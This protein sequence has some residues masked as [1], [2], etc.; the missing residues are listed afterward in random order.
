MQTEAQSITN[1]DIRAVWDANAAFWDNHMG[2]AGND[3]HRELVAPAAEE[4]LALTPG[5]RVLEIACGAGLFARRMAE[6]G[7]RVTAT[8]L[9][10]GM[11]EVAKARCGEHAT[12]ID[13]RQLDAADPAQLAALGDGSF[14]A[15]VCNMAIM[16]MIDVAPLFTALQRVLVP[17]GRVVFT[18]CHPCF[19]TTGCVRVVEEADSGGVIET[20]YGVKVLKY[21]G[22]GPARGIGIAGQPMPQY[23]FDRTLADLL[24]ACFRA[25]LVMDGILEPVFRSAPERPR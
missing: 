18:L 7:A 24:G 6:L 4:L 19:N 12:R 3:F 15:A 20:H 11:I 21:K 25:G 13:F 8:D 22:L 10:S 1:D 5:E 23:Y 9:S 2:D 17:G 16:D 14:D